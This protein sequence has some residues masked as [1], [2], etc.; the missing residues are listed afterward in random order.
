MTTANKLYELQNEQ[1]EECQQDIHT[2]YLMYKATV[3]CPN[4]NCILKC[5]IELSELNLGFPIINLLLYLPDGQKLNVVYSKFNFITKIVRLEIFEIKDESL[6]NQGL[7]TIIFRSWLNVVR[8][9]TKKYNFTVLAIQGL[10]SDGGNFTSTYSK[11]LYRNFDKYPYSERE[12]LV[13]NLQE[14]ERNRLEYEIMP[15]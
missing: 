5:D 4:G 9:F 10:I 7:G 2:K 8:F 11:K 6:R 14:F 3:S 13:L 1:F 12:H 15:N